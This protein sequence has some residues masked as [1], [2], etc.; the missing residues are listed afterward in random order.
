MAS[1]NRSLFDGDA[2][3]CLQAYF[4]P[5]CVFGLTRYRL[6]RIDRNADP[7][8]L[9]DYNTSNS[10][11][12]D[13]C[14]L[15]FPLCI[16]CSVLT[17]SGTRR[18]RMLYGI[19]GSNKND[20]L[21]SIFCPCCSVLRNELEVRT[22]EE[23]KWNDKHGMVVEPYVPE[24][25]MTLS[26]VSSG[27]ENRAP[28]RKNSTR[29]SF[30][31]VIRK[32]FS[33][34][35][36][37]SLHY[38]EKQAQKQGYELQDRNTP[39]TTPPPA[40][41]PESVRSDT[42]TLSQNS[43]DNGE[44]TTTSCMV[45]SE[46]HGKGYQHVLRHLKSGAP[47]QL[48]PL[49]E[50]W[51]EDT[52]STAKKSKVCVSPP[53]QAENIP[54]GSIQESTP[55]GS[56]G[57]QG[58]VPAVVSSPL[59][60]RPVSPRKFI[61]RPDT[62]IP[63]DDA[64]SPALSARSGRSGR[65]IRS[66]RFVPLVPP[67]EGVPSPV[68]ELVEDSQTP[69]EKDVTYQG[70]EPFV[71]VANEKAPVHKLS[72]ENLDE[73]HHPDDTVP[74]VKVQGWLD[75]VGSPARRGSIDV[76]DHALPESSMPSVT[77]RASNDSIVSN[78]TLAP[79]A[80]TPIPR[81]EVDDATSADAAEAR[82]I[83]AETVEEEQ[84]KK[85]AD[86][87][88]GT[89]SCLSATI[90]DAIKAVMPG[91][92]VGT[93]P[94][95]AEPATA[96]PAAYFPDHNP[97]VPKQNQASPPA[98]PKLSTSFDKPSSPVP[99]GS[100]IDADKT[101][102][103]RP[104]SIHN[105]SPTARRYIAA[106]Q[107]TDPPPT[108]TPPSPAVP[109]AKSPKRKLAS[110]SRIPRR[111]SG[112]PGL[113]TPSVPTAVNSYPK[114]TLNSDTSG[115]KTTPANPDPPG[116]Y[117]KPPAPAPKLAVDTPVTPAPPGTYPQNP[118]P[119]QAALPESATPAPGPG[120]YP[121]TPFT[122]AALTPRV[123]ASVSSGQPAYALPTSAS[124][125]RQAATPTA[126]S[127]ASAAPPP[128]FPSP[129]P[130]S[131]TST[132]PAPPSTPQ[133]PP[134]TTPLPAREQSPFRPSS[135]QADKGPF[136]T[137]RAK[138]LLGHYLTR[139]APKVGPTDKTTALSR[140]GGRHSSRGNSLCEDDEAIAHDRRVWGAAAGRKR[141]QTARG[142]AAVPRPRGGGEGGGGGQHGRGGGGTR[143]GFGRWER[144]GGGTE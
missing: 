91:T 102:I 110:E 92:A 117:P 47:G 45:A 114:E 54:L 143:R 55:P 94:A 103:A 16:S 67:S 144:G 104:P 48:P 75:E 101:P 84:T 98:L 20:V 119:P 96:Q 141:A 79:A 111:P 58:K 22:R 89:L 65:S 73:A 113:I 49:V 46:Q 134:T 99:D 64:M 26:R 62:P 129:P 6:E 38:E 108:V 139:E 19:K 100:P 23:E 1:W 93:P 17:S 80:F 125:A 24:A 61:D 8:D 37:R 115:Q 36:L 87:P 42:S 39:K 131:T 135:S 81:G 95:P 14:A 121:A 86:Q 29:G 71:A 2:H 3:D 52:M 128:A 88:T 50:R 27:K 118:A 140:P 41:R 78:A 90:A 56:H 15:A 35:S 74:H 68:Q 18:I 63:R 9:D 127:I 122:A 109:G 85:P 72:S 33:F 76:K 11:C 120:A 130:S 142:A 10:A 132:T 30:G 5:C 7:L 53:Q 43:S 116:T 60:S 97:T 51:S 105:P 77:E 40:P 126:Q 124:V 32:K 66:P 70:H 136:T 69:V 21:T 133:L 4:T 107:T 106:M 25:L 137:F 83:A 82:D 59:V 12:W 13:W 112:T 44:I 34:P 28:S 138:Q 57:G 31:S 123:S